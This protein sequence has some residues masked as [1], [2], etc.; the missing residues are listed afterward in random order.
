[1]K[2]ALIL[3]G[4]S[5]SPTGNWFEWLKDL[6]ENNGYGQVWVPQLPYADK[7]D[8][9]T[10]R[11]FIFASDFEFD[12][13]TLLVGHSSGAV[14]VLSLLEA[15][16]DGLVIDTAVMVGVYR[17]EIKHYS[18]TEEINL[19]K[20]KNKSNRFV[21]LHSDDDPYCPPEHAVFFANEL[22]GELVMMKNEDHFSTKLNPKHT[23][24]P[25][26]VEILGLEEKNES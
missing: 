18:S 2:K 9:K 24:L 10:Y 4:T 14:A 13:E 20:V 7:P 21:F 23:T 5:S 25:K 22:A 1:M 6:L 15:L 3:H 26:M 17:P 8:M 16:Q 11:D 12:S 19:E